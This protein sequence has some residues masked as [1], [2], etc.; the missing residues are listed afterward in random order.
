MDSLFDPMCVPVRVTIN[1]LNFLASRIS[2]SCSFMQDRVKEHDRDIQ[3]ARTQTSPVSEHANEMG[4]LP[5]WK[6]VKF[7]KSRIK[8]C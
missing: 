2:L 6:E 7:I 4:H 3:L 1:K 8:K 5:I